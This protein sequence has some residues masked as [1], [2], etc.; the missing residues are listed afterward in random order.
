MLVTTTL[1]E[2]TTTETMDVTFVLG[3]GVITVTVDAD[4]DDLSY[5]VTAAETVALDDLATRHD[6]LSANEVYVTNAH[7]E[8]V[9]VSE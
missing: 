2:F 6:S 9:E 3:W 4:T 1:E 5:L 8:T 7:G